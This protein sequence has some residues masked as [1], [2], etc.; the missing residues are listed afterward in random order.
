MNIEIN[1]KNYEFD[2]GSTLDS[3]VGKLSLNPKGIAFAI[4]N[5]VIKRDKWS[6]TVLADGM[7]IIMIKAVCGG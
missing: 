6:D 4:D 5:Q 7:K 2:N 3:I 1:N